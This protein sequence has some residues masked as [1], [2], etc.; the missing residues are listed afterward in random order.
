VVFL[1]VPLG[2]EVV[3]DLDEDVADSLVCELVCARAKP[4]S[5]SERMAISRVFMG[6]FLLEI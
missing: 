6:S 5:A 2:L 1:W 3:V 4:L